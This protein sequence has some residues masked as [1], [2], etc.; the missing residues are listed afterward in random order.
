MHQSRDQSYT[1]IPLT[2]G[3]WASTLILYTT[4][5]TPL[6]RLSIANTWV[7]SVVGA[8][9]PLMGW[10]ACTGTLDPGAFILGG[11]LYSWQ[12]PHFNAL[13]WNLRADYSRAGYRM[14]SVL[15]PELC[16]KVTLR[17]CVS[18]VAL[19]TL[20]PVCD[21]TTWWLALDSLPVNLW[22]TWLAWKFHK[23]S[24]NKSARELFRFSLLHLPILMFL[25]LFH[26]KSR[27]AEPLDI[28]N[29]LQG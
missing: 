23:Q 21:V 14:M 17:H 4:V 19:S 8:L 9:P 10:T 6:K 3:L 27:K 28:E 24:D 5:Y 1:A 12:F 25:V 18:L 13:S 22:F 26:K 29:S 20:L 11:I 16:R 7:G 2:D 15:N